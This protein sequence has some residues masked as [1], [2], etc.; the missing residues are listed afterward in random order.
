MKNSK[1]FYFGGRLLLSTPWS[2]LLLD[3][4]QRTKKEHNQQKRNK[5]EE[6]REQEHKKGKATQEERGGRGSE[7]GRVRE[8]S[9]R[10]KTLGLRIQ[11]SVIH[12]PI[13]TYRRCYNYWRGEINNSRLHRHS[14]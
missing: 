2:R 8:S 13:Y 12:V 3:V 6:E 11:N 5:G 4:T 10:E 7:K 9:R 1:R 14:K